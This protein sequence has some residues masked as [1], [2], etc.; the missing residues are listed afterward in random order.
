MKGSPVLAWCLFCLYA[1]W[2]AALQGSLADPRQLGEWTPDLGLVLLFAWAGRLTGERGP[3]AAVLVGLTR[4]GFGA[5][6]PTALVAGSLGAFGLFAALQSA[7]EVD[8]VLPR[9]LLCAL[10]AWLSAGLLFWS[11]TAVLAAAAPAVELEGVRLWPGALVTGLA[12]IV[13]APLGRRL[14]GLAPLAR[15]R[16]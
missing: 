6:A 15:R 14:P 16:P 5:D 2:A 7:L 3:A 9:A 4:A 11:R 1:V 8:R 13:L 10:A 12:C